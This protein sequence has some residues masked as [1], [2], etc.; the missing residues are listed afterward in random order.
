MTRKIKINIIGTTASGKS[1]ILSLF[2]EFLKDKG[3]EVEHE[4][5]YEH[6]DEKSFDKAMKHNLDAKI[7]AI[8]EKTKIFIK[9]VQ[10]S[11]DPAI[12]QR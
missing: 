3:F 4:I 1:T 12:G 7:D 6:Q 8:K 10:I 11:R 9:E 2:K 5:N